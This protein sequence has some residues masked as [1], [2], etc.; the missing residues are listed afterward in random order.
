M[1]VNQQ[2]RAGE[3]IGTVGGELTPEGA[4][5]EFQVRIP[6]D[7]SIEPVDPLTWLRSRSGPP[8]RDP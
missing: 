8:S 4:H 1:E 3:Q 6:L 5:I 2:V 7:G